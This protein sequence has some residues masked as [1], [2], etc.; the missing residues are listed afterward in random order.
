[1]TGSWSGCVYVD[2]TPEGWPLLVPPIGNPAYLPLDLPPPITQV[3]PAVKQAGPLYTP[4]TR[5]EH[6]QAM[7]Y[8]RQLACTGYATD[9]YPVRG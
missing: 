9:K 2:L 5:H 1:M 3:R 4:Y 8:N 7:A 6:A